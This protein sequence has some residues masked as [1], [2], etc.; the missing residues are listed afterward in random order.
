MTPVLMQHSDPLAMQQ[1]WESILRGTLRDR[2]LES[3]E[4]IAS[5]L[6]TMPE[7]VT[8]TDSMFPHSLAYGGAGIALFLHY[9]DRSVGDATARGAME[10][11]LEKAQA[12]LSKTRMEANLF[13]GFGG[14][15]W[16][17]HHI[18][19]QRGAAWKP[20]SWRQIDSA[21]EAWAARENTPT[22]LLGGLGGALL[23]AAEHGPREGTMPIFETTLSRLAQIAESKGRGR[24][25]PVSEAI[26]KDYE[27]H[28]TPA[29]SDPFRLSES[30]L[31]N[32]MTGYYKLSLAHGCMGTAG[33]L[34]SAIQSGF[35]SPIAESLAASAAEFV[36]EAELPPGS[37]SIFPNVPGTMLGKWTGGW[38]DGDAGIASVILL[39]AHVLGR[40]DLRAHALRI[41]RMEA[42]RRRQDVEEPNRDNYMLCHGSSG[43]AH[44]FNRLYQATGESLFAETSLYWFDQALSN[45][46]PGQG[47]GGFVVDEH[48]EDGKLLNVYGLLMGA[49]GLGLTLAAACHSIEPEWDRTLLLSAGGGR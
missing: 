19:N 49:A 30:W 2:A 10:N 44:I 18:R 21:V 38:C 26:Q 23:Y 1:S 8:Q 42:L 9:W 22:E 34:A 47:T 40:E 37:P 41:A 39:I 32:G 33:A 48:R 29:S 7:P 15:S 24:A 20:S 25:W 13:G 35:R 17:I 46:A 5:D 28:V 43:R 4:A 11:Y 3:A 31:C 16:A 27:W 6:S 45:R 14:V 12:A 36:L